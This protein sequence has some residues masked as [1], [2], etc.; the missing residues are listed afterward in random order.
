LTHFFE[1]SLQNIK[2]YA[3]KWN[4]YVSMVTK[5][6]RYSRL[7]FLNNRS[8]GGFV[9]IKIQLITYYWRLHLK[10]SR[11]LGWSIRH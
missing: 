9:Q 2:T 10:W 8:F 6:V 4:K 3:K 7:K 5:N 1:L 11:Q